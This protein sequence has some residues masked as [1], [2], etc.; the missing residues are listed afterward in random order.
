MSKYLL[1][2]ILVVVGLVGNGQQPYRIDT[3]GFK[4]V[5]SNGKPYYLKPDDTIKA[6]LLACDTSNV[7]QE[8]GPN[9]WIRGYIIYQ[10]LPAHYEAIDRYVEARWDIF[11]YLDD[12]KQPLK[13]MVWMAKEVK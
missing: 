10:W 9:Y 3:T 4:I 1:S 13:L 5:F 11:D 6:F 8:W 12:K 7:H 2:L